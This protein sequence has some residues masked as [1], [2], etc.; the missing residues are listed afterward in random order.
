MEITKNVPITNRIQP[1]V[2]LVTVVET[3]PVPAKTAAPRVAAALVA[4]VLLGGGLRTAAFLTDR[5]LWIDEAMLA[6][7]LVDRSPAQLFD[8]LDYN[9]GAPVAFL[10]AAK[11]SIS[12]FGSSAWALRLVPFLASL[13]G[14]VA[15]TVV[16]RRLLPPGAAVF[17]TALFAVSPHIVSYAGEC[18]QYQSDATLAIGL[19]AVS[20]GL[21]EG[22]GGF[23]RWGSLA[24]AGAAAVW[25]SHPSVF[26]LG[27]IGTAL[28]VW[29]AVER[30]R[31]R[32]MSASATV[33]TWLVSFGACY[34]I[35]LKQLGGNKYLT[36]YWAGHFLP[37]PPKGI[38]DLAWLVD[39]VVAFFVVPGGFGGLMV[40]LGGFAAVLALIGLREFA[41]E[42]WPVAVALTVP[43]VLVLLAS[44]LHKYPI[45]GRLMLF[46]VPIAGLLVARGSWAV[47]EAL[48]EKNRFA[49]V[50]LL[51]LLVTAS[52][53][54]TWDVLQRPLRDE[55]LNPVLERVRSEFQPGD[56]VYV[57]YGAG[58]GFAFYTRT[59]PFPAD[60]VTL[61][62]EHRDDPA[63]YLAEVEKLHGRVWVVFSHPHNYEE[64]VIR[65]A[66]DCHGKCEREVKK[67]GA[68]AYLYRLE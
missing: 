8:K 9:Q 68:G 20:L 12:A 46:M 57:Y 3:G 36:D 18:K 33:A 56:R 49:A 45:G 60:A 52:A 7:N 43:A 2:K 27:G 25:C 14:M 51:G 16:A 38:G 64:T 67:P 5:C 47:F 42:R 37:L 6:L 32:F 21:L 39:H 22:R 58:P 62:E 13:A 19:F 54:Q 29:G 50:A 30:D 26:V 48:N 4:L 31:A 53:W 1:T 28:L 66:L 55:Q 59:Q 15:F 17:A 34:L 35:C 41:R 23:W 44:G 24:V 63:G 40:P 65:T 61:G 11:A 10:L